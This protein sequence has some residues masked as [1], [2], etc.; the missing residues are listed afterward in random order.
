MVNCGGNTTTL[1]ATWRWRTPPKRTVCLAFPINAEQLRAQLDQLHSEAHHTT[2]KANSARLRLM[3]LSEAAEK[4]RRQAAISVQTGR[5]NDARELLF[6]KKK[7]MQALEK[8]KTRITL[9]DE[10][11]SKLNEAISVKETQLIENVA[12]DL[13]IGREDASSAVRIV[14]PKDEDTGKLNEE[15]CL[16]WNT[17]NSKDQV[18]EVHTETQAGQ[19][20]GNSMDN[21]TGD[22]TGDSRNDADIISSLK[23]ISSYEDFIEHLDQ[24]LDKIEAELVIVLRVS[25]FVL[26]DNEKPKNSKVQQTLELLEGIHDLRE[27]ISSIMNKKVQMT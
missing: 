12:S 21:P 15:E 27:R 20:I 1:L 18:L 7:V 19:R 16:D 17:I 3:R 13:D 8:S 5:E 23:G 10:L 22:L 6:Q 9:L 25:T 14:S 4:L 11:S 2:A 26:E 24:Q